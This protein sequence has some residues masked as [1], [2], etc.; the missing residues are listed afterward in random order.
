MSQ[1]GGGYD[2]APS[3]WSRFD[4]ADEPDYDTSDGPECCPRHGYDGCACSDLPTY[5]PEETR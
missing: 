3:E 5:L 2:L 4:Y 1:Y